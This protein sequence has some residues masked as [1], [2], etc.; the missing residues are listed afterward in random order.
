MAK[1]LLFTFDV[2]TVS[3]VLNHE[4]PN[5]FIDS[6]SIIETGWDHLVAEVNE[7]WIFR[8]PRTRGSIA[9]QERERDL[10]GYLKNHISLLSI[11]DFHYLGKETAFVGYQTI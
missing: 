6:I 11:P 5:L 4:I 8:F 3:Q 1:K 9:N 2:A 7:E 10:L